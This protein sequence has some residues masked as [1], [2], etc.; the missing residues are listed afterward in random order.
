MKTLKQLLEG[1][2]TNISYTLTGDTDQTISD[3]VYDTP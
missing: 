3:I 1:I 2:K